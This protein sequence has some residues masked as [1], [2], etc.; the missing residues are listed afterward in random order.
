MR[1]FTLIELIFSVAIVGILVS[2]ALPV[3]SSYVARARR[4]DARAQLVQVAQFMQ[5]FYAANDSYS[6][7]RANSDVMSAVPANL[8]QSPA[9]SA[10][11]YDLAIPPDTL[12]ATG[13]QLQMIPFAGSSMGNDMCGTFTLSSVG[14]RGVLV[15]GLVG[16][17]TLRDTCWK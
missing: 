7:D 2:I 6:K 14:L 13:F 12:S 11:L 17:T 1:G 3:Y 8:L 16:D 9:D 10:K 4:A 5:R 15:G